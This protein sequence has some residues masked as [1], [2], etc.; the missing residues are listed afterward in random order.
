MKIIQAES[1][2]TLAGKG[3]GV[4]SKTPSEIFWGLLAMVAV[5]SSDKYCFCRVGVDL[6]RRV[7]RTNAAFSPNRDDKSVFLWEP[8]AK[9]GVGGGHGPEP[10]KIQMSACWCNSIQP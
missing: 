6:F 9:G 10:I 1:K 2:Q 8:V 7:L 4:R 5:T 3:G